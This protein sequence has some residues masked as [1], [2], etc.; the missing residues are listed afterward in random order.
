MLVP[1]RVPESD[2][3]KRRTASGIVDD[4]GDDAFEVAVALAEIEAP[5][6]RRTLAMVRVGL[7]DGACSLTLSSD[8][9]THG[10]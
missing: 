3:S 9:A 6:P 7:E 1:E 2:A 4:L 5:E 8:Y 10:G